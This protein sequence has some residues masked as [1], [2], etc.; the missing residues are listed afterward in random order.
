MQEL[1][2]ATLGCQRLQ[3]SS[4]PLQDIMAELMPKVGQQQV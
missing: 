4:L 3:V 1:T 2:S